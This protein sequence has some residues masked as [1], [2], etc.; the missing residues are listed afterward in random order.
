MNPFWR[1]KFDH[2]IFWAATVGFHIFTRIELINRAGFDQFALEII[3]RNVLLAILIYFNWLFLIPRYA[4]QKKIIAYL[5]LLITS[6]T[7]YALL[8]N[9]HDVYLRG[10]IMGDESW[11]FFFY[12][13]YYNFSIGFFYLAFHVAIQL[14][15]EWYFQRELIRKMEIEKLSSELEYLKAQINPHFVFNSINT[16]YF[17]IDKQNIPARE[18]LSAF[19]EMLRYQLYECNGK[20]IAIEKEL[21]YLKNYVSLQR[22]RKDEN[23]AI[24]FVVEENVSGFTISPLLLIPFVENAFKHISHHPHKNEVRIKIARHDDRVELSVFNTKGSKA[25]TNDHQGIGLKNVKRRLELLYENRHELA[26][27]DKTDSYEVHLTLWI[28]GNSDKGN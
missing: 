15:K 10:Y 16:I 8:K 1:Y 18:S 24:S 13:T 4:Q 11:K 17:Q 12:N 28:D 3:T 14:S 23:Y 21:M 9:V 5:F 26:I 20:E 19:S 7:L 2:I 22:M 6:L 27:D 25:I